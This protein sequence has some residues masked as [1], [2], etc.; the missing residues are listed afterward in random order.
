MSTFRLLL[1]IFLFVACLMTAIPF[2]TDIEAAEIPE[3]PGFYIA[4]DQP[5]AWPDILRSLGLREQA[6]DHA[7]VIIAPEGS[8]VEPGLMKSRPDR[9]LILEGDSKAAR[10][11]GICPTSRHVRVRKVRD[12]H[13]PILPIVWEKAM[14][15][16]VFKVPREAKILLWDCVHHAPLMAVLQTETGG[17][18]WIATSPGTHGYERYPFI[19]QTLLEMGLKPMFESRRLW[20]FFDPAFQRDRDIDELACE[21]RQ[22]GLASTHVGAWD[23]F[24]ASTVEDARL[25]KLI[26]ACHREGI[27]VYAWLELPH[28]SVKFWNR[29]SQWREKTA[30]KKDAEV[31][32][33]LLMNLANPDCRRAVVE[34][35]RSMLE[36]FD[37]DGVNFAELY[38]DGVEGIRNL[39]EFTP[40]NNDVRRDVKAAYGFDPM[41][42][43]SGSR[44]D[45]GKLRAFLEYRVDLAARLQELWIEELEK[46]RADKPHL[47]LVLTYVDDRF[48]STMRD[49]IGA[50]AARSIREIDRHDLTFIIEDPCT[51]WRMGPKRYTEIAARYRPL[52]LRQERLGVDINIVKR[53]NAYPTKQQTGV[54]L[55]QLIRTAAT[56]FPTVM[57]YYTGSIG[58][59]DAPLLPVASA[60]VSQVERFEDALMVES[61]YGVGV[62]WVGPATLDG[63]TWPVQDGERV[64]A[65]PGKHILRCAIPDAPPL[66][67]D[68]TG[69]L[70]SAV[71]KPDGVEITYN[72]QSRAF[73]R[74]SHKPLRLLVDG[75]E[76]TLVV[77]GRYVLQLPRGGHMVRIFW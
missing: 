43:F 76:D 46:M 5:G 2:L 75:R 18:L 54:E 45:P 47:D 50:D 63:K 4:A 48:D 61:P 14:D 51:L 23:Y 35:V 10:A 69:N 12:A 27:L 72:S 26:E 44:R 37:W 55:A 66:V 71:T 30:L 67:T 56:S 41:E 31:G 64:W 34:G 74:L 6:S 59:M 24:E 65:P 29:H 38:F 20:A 21:W 57:Y 36:R 60:V 7:R 73:A 42:L 16:P 25:R 1:R 49:A 11:L 33:R 58:P 13:R 39:E 8:G 3:V 62:R 22:M 52:T 53:N 40:L 15:V 9:I 19:L 17:V 28:V 70:E 68:F 32:W 77:R